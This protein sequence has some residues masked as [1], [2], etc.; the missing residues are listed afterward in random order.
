MRCPTRDR[1]LRYVTK[2][3]AEIAAAMDCNA[4][5]VELR[6]EVCQAIVCASWPL[7]LH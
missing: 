5:A 4:V 1:L 6:R 3:L 7:A 2:P